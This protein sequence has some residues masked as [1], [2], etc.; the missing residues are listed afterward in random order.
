M[1]I[2][3]TYVLQLKNTISVKDYSHV[4][5]IHRSHKTAI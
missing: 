5:V 3:V 2:G 4:T 1:D